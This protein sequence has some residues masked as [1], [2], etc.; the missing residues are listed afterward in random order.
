MTMKL[1]YMGLQKKASQA[2]G[3]IVFLTLISLV[4][5]S[6]LAWSQTKS[7]A[8][9]KDEQSVRQVLSTIRTAL[10]R[11]DEKM[12]G[13]ALD[14][15]YVGTNANGLMRTKA[16]Y[17]AAL[18]SVKVEMLEYHEIQVR[19]SG[20]TA[21]VSHRAT[22]KEQIGGELTSGQY[23]FLRVFVKQHGQWRLIA[24]QGTRII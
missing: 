20:N 19:I 23:R 15:E 10:L 9:K 1:I 2:T 22:S 3:I 16:E 7:S 8:L 14:D 13:S 5:H 6:S 12:L 17:L 18:K 4:T 11:N 24:H 21:I